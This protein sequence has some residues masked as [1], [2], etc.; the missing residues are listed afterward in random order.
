MYNR[1]NRGPRTHPCR[2]P[3]LTSSR[4]DEIP[5]IETYCIL[6]VR[7]DLNQSLAIPLFP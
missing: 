7:S 6:L 5:S 1:K 4:S 2:T 3:K